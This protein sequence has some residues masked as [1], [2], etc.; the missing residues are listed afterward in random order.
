MLLSFAL[1]VFPQGQWAQPTTLGFS[2][3]IVGMLIAAFNKDD[4]LFKKST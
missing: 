2:T 4:A 1:L 3:L